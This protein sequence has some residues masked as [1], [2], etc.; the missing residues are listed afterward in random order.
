MQSETTMVD[1][2]TV[3]IVTDGF[4][5]TQITRPK[6]AFFLTVENRTGPRSLSLYLENSANVQVAQGQIPAEQTEQGLNYQL[7]WAE[8]FD[9]PVGTYVL[10]EAGNPTWACYITIT[11]S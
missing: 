11:G 8:L 4:E 2:E 3:V 9:L 5:P 1:T 6:G 7:G 10:R